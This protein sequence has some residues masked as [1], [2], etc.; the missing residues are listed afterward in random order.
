MLKSNMLSIIK[1]KSMSAAPNGFSLS[2]HL[3]ELGITTLWN[4]NGDAFAGCIHL[5]NAASSHRGGF[6]PLDIAH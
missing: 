4:I 1:L 2:V 6:N 3:H 5:D